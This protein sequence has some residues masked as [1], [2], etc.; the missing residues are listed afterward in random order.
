MNIDLNNFDPSKLTKKYIIN[1]WSKDP[2]YGTRVGVLLC[3]V[4]RQINGILLWYDL[5]PSWDLQDVIAHGLIL[6][7]VISD[8]IV[9]KMANRELH[10]IIVIGSMLS[11]FNHNLMIYILVIVYFLKMFHEICEGLGL[12]LLTPVI[13]VYASGVW[14]LLH[15]GH[16]RHFD[17]ISELGNRLLIGVHDDDD[18]K[19]YKRTPTL[20]MEERATTASYCKGVSGV[21]RSAPLVLTKEF[22]NEHNIHKVVAS[23]EY[24]SPDD[25]YYRV[26]REMGILYI[27]NRI[28][29]VST[30]E[31]MERVKKNSS[32]KLTDV[33]S[34]EKDKSNYIDTSSE[35]T[36]TQT[37]DSDH[38][39]SD[40]SDHT[41]QSDHINDS[42]DI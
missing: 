42:N 39:D 1:L 19:K 34:S 40:H 21:I 7:V 12:P 3:L 41:D 6:S 8:L 5:I 22:I 38:S 9:A 20:T 31:I 36:S 4:M 28:P 14:D 26:P 30:T 16:M 15:K 2:H 17:Q 23:V 29:G 37:I 11:V 27:I 35:Q 25:E 24:D 10:P 18:V 13:N 33:D 32:E